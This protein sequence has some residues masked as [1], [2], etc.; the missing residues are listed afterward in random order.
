MFS[1]C[2]FMSSG[3]GWLAAGICLPRACSR[4][5]AAS[6]TFT[7]SPSLEWMSL[8]PQARLMWFRPLRGRMPGCWERL[9]CPIL[10][11][12]CFNRLRV[13]TGLAYRQGRQ[14][15]LVD[16]PFVAVIGDVDVAERGQNKGVVNADVVGQRTLRHGDD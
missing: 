8:S 3:V 11:P 9:C 7:V 16:R 15:G 14:G 4:N 1:I 12:G 10:K 6:V 2:R 13:R 5:C